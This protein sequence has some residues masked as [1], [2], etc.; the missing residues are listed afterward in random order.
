MFMSHKSHMHTI[1]LFESMCFGI[2]LNPVNAYTGSTDVKRTTRTDPS[3]GKLYYV[4][5]P[6]YAEIRV[7]LRIVRAF[8]S[9]TRRCDITLFLHIDYWYY[10]LF[11]CLPLRP[12]LYF[13]ITSR[14]PSFLSNRNTT[15][16]F[17]NPHRE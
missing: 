6:T 12:F 8:H 4:H 1:P 13:P 3:S 17:V 2:K 11:D 10:L 16:A 15:D 5:A 9:E 7:F 14:I